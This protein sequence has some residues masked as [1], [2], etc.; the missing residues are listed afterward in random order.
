MCLASIL[1]YSPKTIQR[2]AYLT[3]TESYSEITSFEMDPIEMLAK[4]ASSEM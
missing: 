4:E 3:V 2:Y 1:K